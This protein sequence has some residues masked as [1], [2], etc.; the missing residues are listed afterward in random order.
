VEKMK[1]EKQA[2]VEME[3]GINGAVYSVKKPTTEKTIIIDKRSGQE[4]KKVTEAHL[5][6]HLGRF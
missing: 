1:E 3:K 6:L 2:R 5:M 4:S